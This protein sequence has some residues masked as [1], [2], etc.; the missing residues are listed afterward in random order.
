[1]FRCEREIHAQQPQEHLLPPKPEMLQL[2]RDF[3]IAH[4]KTNLG[5]SENA[6]SLTVIPC[7]G[8]RA[9]KALVELIIG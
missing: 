5:H 8:W 6:D 3:E 1:M 4:P 7:T 2:A 9:M